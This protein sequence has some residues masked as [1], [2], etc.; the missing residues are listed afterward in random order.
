MRPRT[1]C[2]PPSPTPVT[3]GL[4]RFDSEAGSVMRPRS[5]QR[6][7]LVSHVRLDRERIEHMTEVLL[8]LPHM[9]NLYLQVCVAVP[10]TSNPNH[11]HADG[12]L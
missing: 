6:A 3:C 9:S 12:A 11:C 5:M 8:E 1:A 4:T 2:L 10:A 7:R